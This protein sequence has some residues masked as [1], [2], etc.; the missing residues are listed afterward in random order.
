MKKRS[1]VSLILMVLLLSSLTAQGRSEQAK[2]TKSVNTVT[3]THELG[4]TQVPAKAERILV[5]DLGAL[6]ILDVLGIDIIGLGKGA[7]LPE[8]LSQYG[9][10]KRYPVVGS[11]HEPDFE[12]VF[13]MQPDLILIGTRAAEAYD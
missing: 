3:V 10:S 7:T 13:E 11:L 6:D 5:F 12:R 9:D 1:I 8:H 4:T 2:Q